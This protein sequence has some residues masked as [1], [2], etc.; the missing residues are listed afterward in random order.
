MGSYGK[1]ARGP[2]TWCYIIN[3]LKGN[4]GDTGKNELERGYGRAGG[5][6]RGPGQRGHKSWDEGGLGGEGKK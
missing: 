2:G 6:C 1:W 5:A 4:C 3:Q